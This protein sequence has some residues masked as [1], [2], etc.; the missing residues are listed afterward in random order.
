[1]DLKRSWMFVPGHRQ[2][3]IDKALG[4]GTD[5]VMLDIEDG[6]APGEKDTARKLIAEALGRERLRRSP[7]RFVRINAIGHER[8][9]ADLE[10]VLRPGLD[11]LVLPKVETP[12]EVLKVDAILKEREPA[13]KVERGSVKFLVAIESPRGLLN[14]PAIAASTARVIGLMF[15]AEDYGRE[16]G[17]PTSREGEARDLIYARSAMVVA[18]ASA[19]VQAVD[20]VWVDLQDSEGLLGFAR[21]SRRLGFSGMSLIHPSQID[22]INGVFSPTPGELDYAQRVVQAY[23]EALARGDGS[24]SFGGQLIDRPIV[25]RARRTLEMAEMLERRG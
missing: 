5:A 24:I 9:A 23:E 18:A 21:Q 6:V 15:G 14:A 10:A 22:P 7:A 2:K 13:V 19:H 25:E 1:M 20:G 4:L 16:L 11:G 8:M 17:L 12:E 3:M